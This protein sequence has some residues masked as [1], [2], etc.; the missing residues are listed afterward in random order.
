L[1]R[2]A[3]AGGQ[4]SAQEFDLTAARLRVRGNLLFN[5]SNAARKVSGQI[6]ADDLILPLPN[7]A[8]NV[9]LPL[10]FLHGWDG[11]VRVGV[12]RLTLGE[13]P[14]V[15]DVSAALSLTR[16]VLRLDGITARFGAGALS[17]NLICNAAS[18][19]PTI[20]LHGNLA[21]VSATA[22]PDVAR[23]GLLSGQGNARIA[24]AASGFSPSALLAT[25]HGR[26]DVILHDGSM[27][28]FDLFR[29]KQAVQDWD[30]NT[31]GVAVSDTLMH[32]ST[33][34]DQLEVAAS[35]SQ[36]ALTLD[37]ASLISHAGAAHATG[38]MM[39]A[40][41]T[42]D[43]RLAVRPDVPHAPELGIRLA[44]P[45]EHP[46]RTLELAGLARWMADLAR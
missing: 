4:I 11:D 12:G 25:L 30:S 22:L 37:R 41:A 28:G 32:G 29:L 24:L 6:D 31:A 23:Y 46:S 9:P 2:V 27:A 20:S 13:G 21:D 10:D 35:I 15:Q 34:F 36:G 18:D 1:A 42:L 17:G 39:L 38:S 26:F 7:L 40:D 19:P 8:S 45:I 5:V 33:G 16:D 14:V 44:G 3:G 43:V